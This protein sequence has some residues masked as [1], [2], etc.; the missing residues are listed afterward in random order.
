MDLL[1][2]AP[3]D[4]PT[5]RAFELAEH[6]GGDP[7]LLR[8]GFDVDD[9]EF[10]FAVSL[11]QAADRFFAPAALVPSPLRL[12]VSGNVFPAHRHPA[13][14]VKTLGGQ[15]LT[16]IGSASLSVLIGLTGAPC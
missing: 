7:Q 8:D 6:H 12:V 11:Q 16:L 14:L 1:V 13:D 4:L 10:L 9:C 15:I 3:G 5:E 2:V